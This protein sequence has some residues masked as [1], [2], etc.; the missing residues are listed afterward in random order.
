V[1]VQT[2]HAEKP[3]H[4]SGQQIQNMFAPVRVAARAENAGGLVQ[5]DVDFL[6]DADSLPVDC[7]G[8]SGR[9]DLCAE[10]CED[11]A[12]DGNLSR[13]DELFAPTPRTDASFSEEFLQTNGVMECC[14]GD[15]L[16]FH[17]SIPSLRSFAEIPR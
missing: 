5:S 4:R 9:I 8:V 7:D 12:V 10:A 13:L 1:H 2:P 14:N 15:P 17:Y 3:R 6:F 11:L 16:P